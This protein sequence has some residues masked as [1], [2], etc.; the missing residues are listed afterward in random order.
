VEKFDS[1]LNWKVMHQGKIMPLRKAI[2][3]RK[4]DYLENLATS[5]EG[6]YVY[7]KKK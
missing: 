4:E 3:K 1:G 2:S 7:Y 5:I 6:W